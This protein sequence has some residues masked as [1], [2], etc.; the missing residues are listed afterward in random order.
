MPGSQAGAVGLRA[1]IALDAKSRG[2][3]IAMRYS[4]WRGACTRINRALP[5]K[6]G[7]GFSKSSVEMNMGYE[8]LAL[9]IFCL[10][11]A[12]GWLW[13]TEQ[14][15]RAVQ[16]AYDEIRNEIRRERSNVDCR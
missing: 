6:M 3:N 12:H 8:I 13:S 7:I 4:S 16:A 11:V 9:V 14:R 5:P 15:R 2:M 1:G 10:A